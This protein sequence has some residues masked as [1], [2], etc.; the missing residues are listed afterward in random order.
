M[1]SSIEEL[2]AFITIVDT[3]SFI[4]AAERLGQ[5]ARLNQTHWDFKFQYCTYSTSD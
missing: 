5:T 3:G 2:L 4:A 1:K